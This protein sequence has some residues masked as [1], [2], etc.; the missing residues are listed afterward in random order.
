MTRETR[1]A[2]AFTELAEALISGR[3]LVDFL[4][5]LSCHCVELLEVDAAGV[6][7]GD[8]SGRLRAVGA[9]DEQTHL[10]ELFAL[11]HEEGPCLDVFLKG[12]VEQVGTADVAERW[13]RFSRLVRKS[14]YGW[15]CALPLRHQQQM[16]GAL[17]LFRTEA[18]PLSDEEVRLGQALADVA[19][20]ALLQQR[21]V[22]QA[23]RLAG[24]LQMA[25][26]SRVLIEQAKGILAERLGVEPDVAFG[27]LRREAR[28]S[29]R[30]LHDVA[31]DVVRRP[32]KP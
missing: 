15:I 22:A 17:N 6:M 9:S 21:E 16:I 7:L 28:T 30:K 18:R 3:D 11:Q 23:R 25:L 20:A 14:G 27:H 32:G 2:A 29:N 10:L 26:D 19:T 24:Q 13:P 1:L 4:H 8:E 5:V 31:A 12:A